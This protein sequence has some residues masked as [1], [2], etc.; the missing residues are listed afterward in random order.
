MLSVAEYVASKELMVRNIT[1]ILEK[2]E[3]IYR[4]TV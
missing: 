1:S 4:G 2:V 3:E